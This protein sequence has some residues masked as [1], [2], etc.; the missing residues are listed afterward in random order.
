MLGLRLRPPRQPGGRC[1]PGVRG[2]AAGCGGQSMKRRLFNVAAGVSFGISLLA[3]TFWPLAYWRF[4]QVSY[5]TEGSTTTYRGLAFPGWLVLSLSTKGGIVSG[6]PMQ[7]GWL[8]FAV[9]VRA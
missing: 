4:C 7:E 3:A 1:V 2:G 9:P 8:V 6:V 5:T